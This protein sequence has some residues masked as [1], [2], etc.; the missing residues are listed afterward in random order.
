VVRKLSFLE[1]KWSKKLE[2]FV[3]HEQ[4]EELEF[5]PWAQVQGSSKWSVCLS[6]T[7]NSTLSFK[8]RELKFCIQT[9]FCIFHINIYLIIIADETNQAN[10]KLIIV[11]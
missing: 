5:L 10:R 1:Q 8:A 6:V 4:V 11:R 9:G 2:I 3:L 7:S